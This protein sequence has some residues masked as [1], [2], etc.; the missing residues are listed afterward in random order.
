[1]PLT[2]IDPDDPA[3]VGYDPCTGDPSHIANK[4][5]GAFTFS[6][7]AEI[8][9]QVA[10]EAVPLICR[11]IQSTGEDVTLPGIY[12]ALGK[13]G[14][15]RLSRSAPKFRDRLL[16]L[17]DS[18]GG[19]GTAGYIGLQRRL[20]ALMEGKFGDLFAMRPALDWHEVTSRP[21][22]TY[23]ALSATGASE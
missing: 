16:Q 7:E 22:V 5:V 2:I 23:F 18:A 11:A 4:L 15:L 14:L 3:S 8:Y 1:V 21:G 20:G 17:D 12:D 19:V 6:G 10:M 13:G 9:K